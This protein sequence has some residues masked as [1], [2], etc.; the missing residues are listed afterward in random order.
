MELDGAKKCI[1]FIEKNSLPIKALITDRHKGLAKWMREKH[2]EIIHFF[3]IW[4]IAKSL[5]K[6][7]LKASKEKGCDII[8]DWMTGIRNHLYWCATSTTEGFSQLIV[9]KWKSIMYHVSNRHDVF[10]YKHFKK[11]AHEE[12][13]KKKWIKLGKFVCK[14]NF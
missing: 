5:C 10:P 6:E 9:E 2:P 7:L 12:V 1:A 13:S 14:V 4:H 11:C 8:K 3:D